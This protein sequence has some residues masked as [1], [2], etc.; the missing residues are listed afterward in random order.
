MPKL[1]PRKSTK[2][3]PAPKKAA[4]RPG[5]WRPEEHAVFIEEH[6]RGGSRIEKAAR[7]TRRLGRRITADAISHQLAKLRAEGRIKEEPP[8]IAPLDKAMSM[9]I[10]AGFGEAPKLK[11]PTV[12]ELVKQLVKLTKKPQPREALCNTLDVSPAKLDRLMRVAEAQGHKVRHATPVPVFNIST[13]KTREFLRVII[14]DSH[15]HHI[16]V[17]ARDALL[18]DIVGLKPHQT[19]W[20]GDHLDAGGTFSEHQR[21]YT[22]EMVESYEE[23]VAACNEFLDKY[24]AASPKDED[25]YI[26]GNHEQ[27]IERWAA[28]NAMNAKEADYI[29]KRMGPVAVL[30]LEKRGIKYF[31]RS[32]HYGL[33]IPGAIKLGKCH[34]VHG[35]S[36][37]EHA[38]E[39]HLKRFG[40][41]VVYGHTHRAAYVTERTVTAEG[42]MAANP[43]TLA[44]LQPLYKHT[45][46]TSWSHGY[47]IQLVHPS[48]NFCHIHVPILA[49]VSFLPSVFRDR[50]QK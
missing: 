43:G 16:D 26:E 42:V 11:G 29:L 9:G 44:K 27:H 22:N 8:K 48:G 37:S 32:E 5:D 28:R 13:S 35:I 25:F 41:S 23:D 31:K 3:I 6:M 46:P 24:S 50:G 18:A 33:P 38:A 19:V 15:G 17:P 39:Q 40:A 36:H 14:P 10:A 47:D 7:L 49:G 4:L 20:L 30:G 12:D 34:F 1:K 45:Q 21:V 2:K